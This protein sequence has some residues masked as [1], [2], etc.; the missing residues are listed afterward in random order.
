MAAGIAADLEHIDVAGNVT[1][2]AEL[3][4]CLHRCDAVVIASSVARAS[5]M[6]ADDLFRVNGAILRKVVEACA[7][8]CPEAVLVVLME[9]LSAMVPLAAHVLRRCG[10]KQADQRVVGDTTPDVMRANT[11]L[12][13]S[14]G[15]G[16]AP[17]DLRVPV[18]GGHGAT[19][20]PL[21]S[22]VDAAA[23]LTE[24]ELSA[25]T[26]RVRTSAREVTSANEGRGAAVHAVAVGAARLVAQL[27]AAAE[28]DEQP[29]VHL[30]AKSGLTKAP[31]LAGPVVLGPRG[32]VRHLP[33]GTL[34]GQEQRALDALLPQ[35][36][37]AARQGR[38]LGAA[39]KRSA[40]MTTVIPHVD[41]TPVPPGRNRAAEGQLQAASLPALFIV[42]APESAPAPPPALG[43]ATAANDSPDGPRQ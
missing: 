21:F 2:C 8:A 37:A 17:S 40:G 19:A 3:A 25:L 34:S 38:A 9:P 42:D 23:K 43:T 16:G 27:L 35:L 29:V 24:G 30:F 18:I 14:V 4:D 39:G 7:S 13:Q 32:V 10:V 1:A 20:L 28:G 26:R 15:C 41:A 11:F 5:G 12:G 6:T 36:V 31:Y 22:R 33:L